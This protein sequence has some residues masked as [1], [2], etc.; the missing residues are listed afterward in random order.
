[1]SEKRHSKVFGHESWVCG[2]IGC[3]VG[4]A[5]SPP[6]WRG[7]VV[8]APFEPQPVPDLVGLLH[9]H[10]PVAH[11]AP[12][13]RE[14]RVWYRD[15]Q[16]HV[17][18]P[19]PVPLQVGLD[20]DGEAP[21]LVELDGLLSVYDVAPARPDDLGLPVPCAVHRVGP[22]E[23]VPHLDPD[24]RQVVFGVGVRA[25]LPRHLPVAAPD[26]VMHEVHELLVPLLGDPLS[27]GAFDVVLLDRA[28]VGVLDLPEVL[29]ACLPR[30]VV[31]R[32]LPP[33]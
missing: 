33:P 1:M 7:P 30:V 28:A 22:R 19:L 9:R 23:L 21:A 18:R 20:R 5:S 32:H 27:L 4:C 24:V 13:S 2:K 10:L 8:A 29:Q 12:V 25:R 31:G 15:V 11:H 16:A 14:N 17:H 3:T 6:F 26:A